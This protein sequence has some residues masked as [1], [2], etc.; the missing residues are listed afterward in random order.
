MLPCLRRFTTPLA[1][2]LALAIGLT[3]AP[4]AAQT[5]TGS[6]RGKV[7]DAATAAPVRGAQVFVVGTRVGSVTGADGTY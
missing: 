4:V 1:F 6:V 5:G 7:T 3:G 2:M